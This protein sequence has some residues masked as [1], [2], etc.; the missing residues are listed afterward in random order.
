M[1][2][3]LRIFIGLVIGGFLTTAWGQPNYT[4][5]YTFVTLAGTNAVSGS[6]DGTNGG[7]L[8]NSPQG[9]VADKLG[10]LYVA[11]HVNNIIR[12]LTPSG[13]DWIV[14]TIAGTAGTTGSADGTNG[15]ARFND[16]DG[17]AVDGAGNLYVTDY[18]S[19]TIRKLAP[20]GTNWVVTT[21]AG[22]PASF[23]GN[24]GTNANARFDFPAGITV[25]TNGN[26]Y[27]ADFYN[28]TIRKVT[29][30]GTNW[31]VTT[32]AG[33][34]QDYDSA[35]G[36]NSAAL[37]FGPSGI[38]VDGFGNLYVA[39][40]INQTIRKLTPVGTNWVVTTI[41]GQVQNS[42]A[43]DGT[44]ANSQFNY[45]YGIT[46]DGTGNLYVSDTLNATIRKVASVGTN[47]VVSTLAGLPG[48]TSAADGTGS[49][50]LFVTPYGITVDG[51][52]N[53]YVADSSNNTIRKGYVATIPNLSVAL[54]GVSSVIVSWPGAGSFTLQT[55][56]DLATSNW[57]A[58]GGTIASSN[59]TNSVALTPLAGSLFFRLTH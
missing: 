57:A 4:T 14:T 48:S 34:V 1:K 35:D 9:V 15:V 46:T 24:D 55:N 43:N 59:G 58:Y 54:S 16:P 52:G 23:G 44:N 50:A 37:F 40:T 51:A 19:H 21:I 28:S 22:T 31:I 39:D 32:I 11:D 29:P 33:S 6:A 13:T 2:G 20:V 42:G 10:N 49:S 56:S 30:A 27:V 47:W 7:A 3:T 18:S 12:K 45:P 36:T 5:P 41:A 53:L 26:L 8:F 17:I 38:T 25:D